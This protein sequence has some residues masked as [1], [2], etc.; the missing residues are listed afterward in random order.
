MRAKIVLGCIAMIIGILFVAIVPSANNYPSY[1]E[2]K[3][4]CDAA[5]TSSQHSEALDK[6]MSKFQILP[7]RRN[8]PIDDSFKSILISN[9]I[10]RSAVDS[11]VTCT[12]FEQR[13]QGGFLSRHVC[14]GYFVF[15][16]GGALI[17]YNIHDIFY[18]M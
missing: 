18:G 1:S 11:A 8:D 3:T 6:W 17:E 15:G 14:Y 16:P 7:Q 2:L 5:L 13:V 4:S 9:G 10:S 12:Y